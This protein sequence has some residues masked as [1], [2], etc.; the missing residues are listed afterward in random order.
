MLFFITEEEVPEP[1]LPSSKPAELPRVSTETRKV[2]VII[3]ERR[4]TKPG[5]PYVREWDKGK[6]RKLQCIHNVLD[7]QHVRNPLV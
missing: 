4:D 3:Q 1:V 6:G 2:E 5:V 7:C